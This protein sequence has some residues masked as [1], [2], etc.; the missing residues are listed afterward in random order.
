MTIDVIFL[1]LDGVLFDTEAFHLEAF[2]LAFA[3]AGLQLRWE[4]SEMRK[5]LRIYGTAG[6][7]TAMTKIDGGK[8]AREL[9]AELT[10]LKQ[11]AMHQ[12]V[13]RAKPRVLPAAERLVD[14]ALHAGCK[15]S[16]LS[17]TPA[18]TTAALLE[19]CFGD[20]VNTKF[21]VV[22]GGAKW[23]GTAATGP[24]A[25]A[26]HAMGIGARHAVAIDTSPDAL[27]AARGCGMLTVSAC[28]NDINDASI[29]GADLWCPQLQELR[30]IVPDGQAYVSFNALRGMQSNTRRLTLPVAAQSA[31]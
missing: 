18:A 15:L 10:Q 17:E 7:M 11:R 31:V 25:L 20:T 23:Q 22:A 13:T 8:R 6:V 27:R 14:D 12:L 5:A 21:A 4:M 2:N 30:K 29:S 3:Q 26:M 24:Y 28:P 16:I 19:H 9:A 1:G